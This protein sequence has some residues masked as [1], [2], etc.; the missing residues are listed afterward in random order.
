MKT[1]IY[2]ILLG[3]F[4]YGNQA[5]CQTGFPK[6]S[7]EKH[8]GQPG[9]NFP[10]NRAVLYEQL[11]QPSTEG[12][13]PS[14]MFLDYPTYTCQGADDFFVPEGMPWE[15]ESLFFSGVFLEGQPVG[16]VEVANIYFYG[17]AGNMPGTEVAAFYETP[18]VLTP[19]GNL[20]VTLPSHVV[21]PQ[22]R[23]WLSVQ[24]V[25]SFANSG[26][27]NWARQ[28]Q[29]TINGE[30]HW[31]N[32]G[33]GFGYPGTETWQMASEIP[34]P[35]PNEDLN[36]SFGIYG[37]ISGVP[38]VITHLSCYEP[39]A[40]QNIRVYGEGFGGFAEGCAIDIDGVQYVDE[41]TY[42]SENEIFFDLPFLDGMSTAMFSVVTEFTAFSNPVEI[43][44]YQPTEVYFLNINENDI[45]SGDSLFISV[46]AE[47]DQDMIVRTVFLYRPE[48]STDWNFIGV[49]TVGAA[50]HY[51]TIYPIG[52]GDGWGIWWDYRDIEDD[53]AISINAY[54]QT[55]FG[56][57]LTGEILVTIDTKPLAPVFIPDGS[58]LDGGL[59]ILKDSLV[60]NIEAKNEDTETIEFNWQPW[61]GPSPGWWDIDRGLDSINQMDI[62]FLDK[63]GDTVSHM[64]C[65]PCAMAT[66]LK[67]LARQ[68]PNSDI[69]NMTTDSLARKIARDAGTDS[70]GTSSANLEKAVEDALKNDEGITDD[71][72]ITTTYNKTSSN[73]A[74]TGSHNVSDDIAS[75]LRDSSDVVL[76][77]YQKTNGGDT[78]GHYVTASSYHSQIHY[79]WQGDIEFA[80]QTSHVGFMDPA[81]GQRTDKKI[82][83]DSNPPT[84]EDYDLHPD[85][86]SGTAWVHSVTTIKPKKDK[87]NN[88][89]LIASFPVNGAGN[90][91]LKLACAD[92]PEGNN[93]I[94]VFGV[95]GLGDRAMGSYIRCVNGQYELVP[96]FTADR[97]TCITE[98]PINFT[99]LS[100][101]PDSIKTWQ[102]NFGDGAK[103]TSDERN[104]SYIYD[105]TGV[106]DVSLIVSDGHTSD[107][108]A[109]PGFIHIVDA[110]EQSILKLQGW[111][112]LSSFV[113]P[114]EPNIQNILSDTYDD[115]A[116]MQNFHG[117]IWPAEDINTLENWDTK[118]GYKVKF[119]E[120]VT[121][122]LRGI[123][124]A[125][126]SVDLL[127]G[128]NILPVLSQC[129]M[130][131]QEIQDQLGSSLVMI[132]EIAGYLAFWPEFGVSTL[133]HLAPGTAYMIM[134]SEEG[135]FTF[136]DCDKSSFEDPVIA[137]DA[138]NPWNEVVPSPNSHLICLLSETLKS[139]QIGDVIGVFDP[140]DKC[141]G[142]SEI[143][144][145]RQNL[146]L[147]AFGDDPTSFSQGGLIEGLPLSFRA[148]ISNRNEIIKLIPEYDGSLPDAGTFKTNGLSV[149]KN[150]NFSLTVPMNGFNQRINIFPNPAN[151]TFNIHGNVS[152]VKIQVFNVFGEAI[153]NHKTMLPDKIDISGQ[154]VGVY[155]IKIVSEHGNYFE[156]LIVE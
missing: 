5:D 55:I 41:I 128:W 152:K 95:N 116:I 132:K 27:W 66:C 124:A 99:D 70:T 56:Q 38:S 72:E 120:N 153:I 12:A 96:Y 14:Q 75:G 105:G 82:G 104:P 67:W 103:G 48:G 31:Q 109:R 65:G 136:P 36:L 33:G 84:I 77:I 102:W 42:W 69:G 147:V 145:M 100:M 3:F 73:K 86:S 30:F 85:S 10:D 49:D 81:T 19:D 22:G 60:F 6:S 83:W 148:F 133:S 40:G 139:F 154:P 78:L 71:F 24:P 68:Y 17:D 144:D 58:K 111:S 118:S 32:P 87:R 122:N 98:F 59:A 151:G 54:M 74:G 125:D 89:T 140:R 52:T 20:D 79:G 64:A 35:G 53:Q 130:L 107:T 39:Y 18:V 91:S 2:A 16:L 92:L 146:L 62:A 97:D 106:F 129:P 43:V 135:T 134:L 26:Q 7:I 101:H 51:S 149:V 29:P 127:A 141:I 119:T 114:V 142:L 143:K 50:P 63:E 93:I 46:A 57:W 94:G 156:K 90:Y 4:L 25:M 47:I 76:L 45:L 137:V 21:L 28:V 150:L 110:V 9:I 11:S 13:I 8:A 34:W 117:V 61:F 112:G 121:I 155:F 108:I 23:Y 88:N 15:I 138:A 115:L 1:T 113:A 37:F 131:T 44:I 80:I 126:Q 123:T